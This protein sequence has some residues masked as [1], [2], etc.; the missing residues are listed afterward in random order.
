MMM[1]YLFI[2]KFNIKNK[3]GELNRKD[4]YI[5]FKDHKQKF[6]NNK[7]A[8]LINPT[9]TELDLVFKKIHSTESFPKY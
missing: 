9:E 2:N 5:I 6:E 7:Q 4:A 1:I 3:L 8:S